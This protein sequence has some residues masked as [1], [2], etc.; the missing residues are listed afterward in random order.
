MRDR[1]KSFSFPLEMVHDIDSDVER[2]YE[3]AVRD[4]PWFKRWI[5]QRYTWKPI[6]ALHWYWFRY[7]RKKYCLLV[8]LNGSRTINEP[9]LIPLP[10]SF[11]TRRSEISEIVIAIRPEDRERFLNIMKEMRAGAR[12]KA[13]HGEE[14]K[15]IEDTRG[16]KTART[17]H[18]KEDRSAKK[19]VLKKIILYPLSAAVVGIILL[20]I[21]PVI[22]ADIM[23]GI[24]V[25]L[26]SII[27]LMILLMANMMHLM[28]RVHS[29]YTI[30][31]KG[32]KFKPMAWM[33]IRIDFD[34]IGEVKK[35]PDRTRKS[36]AGFMYAIT[37]GDSFFYP[38][39]FSK[40]LF[41]IILRTPAQ[42]K[43]TGRYRNMNARYMSF[44]LGDDDNF[45]LQKR[46]RQEMLKE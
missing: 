36:M 15:K 42:V 12:E 39:R 3:R 19:Q 11:T 30:Y 14:Q 20:F 31:S 29:S 41:R 4:T 38:T 8:K 21:Y 22:N 35:I 37:H 24:L 10:P 7:H 40:N 23:F 17:I 33:E 32:F 18:V 5:S 6:G 26:F 28:G 1:W 13:F 34:Q 9:V 44:I 16:R 27:W 43:T 45:T 2:Y 25:I 46:I